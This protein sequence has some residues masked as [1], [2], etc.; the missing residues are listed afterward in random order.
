VPVAAD[1]QVSAGSV[2]VGTKELA[3][4]GH[5]DIVRFDRLKGWVWNPDRPD[6]ALTIRVLADGKL[7]VK[8]VANVHRH[9]VEK[10]GFGTGRY[11]FELTNE[12]KPPF[13]SASSPWK[14]TPP[15]RR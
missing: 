14:T 9:D 1:D 12:F 6:E 10:A 8:A 3:I 15:A 4:H 5:L 11:G 13:G 2:A 7:I